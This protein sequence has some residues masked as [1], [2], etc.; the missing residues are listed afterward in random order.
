MPRTP[1]I[2]FDTTVLSAFASTST[3]FVLRARYTGRGCTTTE[4]VAELT[5]GVRSGYSHLDQALAQVDPVAAD[6]WL[7]VLCQESARE[8][9]L[10]AELDAFLGPGEASCLALAKERRLVLATDDLAARR[11]ASRVGVALTG[12]VGI[13]VASVREGMLPLTDANEALA[14]MVRHHYRSPVDRLDGLI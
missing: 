6:G 8:F 11:A 5:Q 9:A 1:S 3:M 4:V 14:A 13:L 7:R 10:R 2:I 12:T